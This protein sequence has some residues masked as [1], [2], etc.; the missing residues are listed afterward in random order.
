MSNRTIRIAPSLLSANFARLEDSVRLCEAGGADV[1]HVDVM[2][3]HFVPNITIGPIVVKALRATTK[4]PLDCHLMIENADDFIPEFAK[5]GADWISVH[6]EACPHLHRTLQL[7]KSFGKKAGVALN[8]GT[9]LSALEGI[10]D[11]CDYI[12]LMSVNPGFGGQAFIPTLFERAREL[13]RMLDARGLHKVFI[14]ADGGLKL[15]NIG[16]VYDAG[17]DVFVSGSG[18][19]GAADVAEMI[20]RMKNVR[21]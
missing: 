15:E 1:L 8:P 18:V 17:V 11:E 7:I 13:R 2:D 12:L 16:E 9:S 5:A 4:L 14:Q 6:V 3:G 19:F 20:R 21:S 10:I